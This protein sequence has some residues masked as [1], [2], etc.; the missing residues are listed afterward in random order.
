MSAARYR[1]DI[2]GL[3]AIAV[4]SVVAFHADIRSLRGGYVG[5]DVFFVI[6]GYLITGIIRDEL[7]AG[8]FSVAEF[9]KR[10]AHRIFP[11]LFAMMAVVTVISAFVLLPSEL[12]DYGWS[13]VATCLSGSNFLFYAETGYFDAEAG[14]KPLLHTW[15]LA[16]EEQYYVV[17]PLLMILL[18]RRGWSLPLS[19]AAL[20]AVSLATS[21][22]WL[23]ADPSGAFYLLPSRAWELLIGGLAATAPLPRVPRWLREAAALAGLLMIAYAVRRYSNVTPFPGLAA[24]VPCVGT[25]LVIAI[26][27]DGLTFVGRGLGL[28]PM[29]W[30]GLISYS[31]YLWHW[32]VIVFA[33]IGLLLPT[34]PLVQAG[35]LLASAGLGAISWRF[36][37]QP[38]QRAR[39]G[40]PRRKSL[41]FAA[42]AIAA[43]CALGSTLVALRGLPARLTPDERQLA[44][45]LT[46]DGDHRYRGGRCFLVGAHDRFD[47]D[48]L[49]RQ[50]S[51]PT[52]LL[53]GDSHAAHLWP[54][55]SAEMAG[56]GTT[57]V[58]ANAAGCKPLM[59][60][61]TYGLARCSNLIGRIL[62]E[63]LPRRPVEA[64]VLAARWSAADLADLPDTL[65]ALRRHAGHVIL[66]G[67]V[68]QYETALPRL[69]I[70]AGQAGDPGLPARHELAPDGDLDPAMRAIAQRAGAAFVS[71]RD[72]LCRPGC[73]T[74]LADG[75][76]TQFDYGHFTEEGSRLVAPAILAG[77]RGGERARA[78]PSAKP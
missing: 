14:A 33:K 40:T 60:L 5:V 35:I 50:S 8:R 68:P 10:R 17:W 62:D 4:L 57:L 55:L 27:R 72:A 75:A 42:A 32:P 26:G 67:R 29:R 71:M 51:Q 46:Y 6:S 52:V 30:I 3:R 7:A 59:H 69:L 1:P 54:G 53:L 43:G 12:V 41:T 15:S 38:V 25:A 49:A 34:T 56:S 66:V 39:A 78:A 61:R 22:V 24:L 2:D 37:E 31:M 45:Y 23:A 16:I 76:P 64:V 58:Q 28:A 20:L 73:V 44:G 74:R 19:T 48:C 70:R 18:A 13:V 9:Y 63:E 47:D 36:V 65:A 77:L 11:A 21:V